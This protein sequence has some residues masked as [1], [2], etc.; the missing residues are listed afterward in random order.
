MHPDMRILFCWDKK[1]SKQNSQNTEFYWYT[2]AINE[3]NI[4]YKIKSFCE[5]SRRWNCKL[6]KNSNQTVQSSV[7]LKSWTS[8]LV[9]GKYIFFF[10]KMCSRSILVVVLIAFT[11]S[12]CFSCSNFE[13]INHLH[14]KC[15]IIQNITVSVFR[16]FGTWREQVFRTTT[17]TTR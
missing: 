3:Q 14:G 10:S 9:L 6:Y 4:V 1:R 12:A 16:S 17:T 5:N 15:L 7:Y 8:Q 13:V 2:I 11:V